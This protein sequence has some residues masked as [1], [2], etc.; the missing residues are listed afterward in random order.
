MSEK[1]YEGTCFIGVAGA[2]RYHV[3]AWRSIINIQ[4]RAGDA[5]PL[6][7][8]GTKGYEVRQ[9]HVNKF[10]ESGH[11]WL[12]MLDHDMIYP[13]DTLEK[14]RS[15]GLPYVS[16]LYMRRQYSPMAPIWFAPNPDLVWP[17]EPWNDKIEKDKLYKIGAS[18]WGCILIHREVVMAVRDLLHY[19]WEVIEDDMDIWPYD[20]RQIL[21]AVK[22]LKLLADRP[23]TPGL[24]QYVKK[25]VDILANEIRPLRGSKEAPIGSDIRFP[26]F[27]QAAGYQLWGDSS[28]RCNHVLDYPLSPDDYDG[29]ADEFHQEFRADIQKKVTD[30]RRAWRKHIRSLP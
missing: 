20:L 14:L 25:Y 6:F 13:A 29:Q 3:N 12:L 17:Y 4:R 18:G 2:E 1:K 28:V 15:H 11:D 23:L 22:W 30:A 26:Y 19:E 21:E 24:R 16:G 10:I 5:A 27:A 8:T 7:G 9:A